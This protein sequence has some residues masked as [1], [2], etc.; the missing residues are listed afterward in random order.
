[1]TPSLP[2]HDPDPAARA[3]LLATQ[4]E[5]YVYDATVLPPFMLPQAL[6]PGEDFGGGTLGERLS[7]AVGGPFNLAAV[8]L[9]GLIDRFDELQDYEDLFRLYDLPPIVQTWRRDE[10]FAEQRLAGVASRLLRRLDRLPAGLGLRADQF[11]ALTGMPPDRA[12]GEGRLYAVDYAPLDGVEVAADRRLYAPMALFCWQDEPGSQDMLRGTARRGRL[13]PVAIQ[14]DQRPTA[15]NLYLPQHGAD[16]LLARTAV[17]AADFTLHFLGH[18]LARCHLAMA[19]FAMA[20]ARQLAP[21]HPLGA[22][23]RP[24]LRRSIAHTEQLRRSFFN[25]GGHIERLLAPTLAGSREIVARA[26]G[27]LDVSAWALPHDLAARGVDDPEYLPHYPFRDDAR[28]VWQALADYVRDY[29]AICYDSD[30]E[31]HTDVELRAWLDELGDP[32]RGNL[33]GLPAW[34]LG[35]AALCELVTTIIFT[36][37]PD[38]SAQNTRQ[39]EY[40]A[41]VPNMPMA[42]YGPLPARGADESALLEILPPQRQALEQLE[43]VQAMTAYQHDRLGHYSDEDPLLTGPERV[44]EA[45]TAF[46]ERLVCIEGEIERR[47]AGRELAYTGMS[48]SKL[49]NAAST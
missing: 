14:L 16:W 18:H 15:H 35:R 10:V 26:F 44:Q 17:Q 8:K 34:P 6:P 36:A 9:A 1:M 30:A 32:G 2:Q 22:L 46:Q 24:H 12:A 31:L 5:R 40:A 42:L 49:G 3:A 47:N 25:P 41:Y 29:L 7:S 27:R 19:S 4:R 11:A 48:P 39:W 45:V 21:A 28:L 13:R 23:L 38:H 43:L 20:T 37:G 33:R